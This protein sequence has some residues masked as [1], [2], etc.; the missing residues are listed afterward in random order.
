[1]KWHEREVTDIFKEL[2]TSEAGLSSTAA[3][4]RL[5]QFGP[6]RLAEEDRISKIRII[7]RQF[8]NPSAY[9]LLIAAGVTLALQEFKD[10]GII[11]AELAPS[12]ALSP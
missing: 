8:A 7:L 12:G 4:D 9:I 6:N 1:M 5:V 10:A 3:A 11:L 2:A